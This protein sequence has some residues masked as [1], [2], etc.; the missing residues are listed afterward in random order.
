MRNLNG[1]KYLTE[2]HGK[3]FCAAPW[4]SIHEGPGGLVSTCCKSREP[5]GWSQDQT[6]EEMYNSDHAKSVRSSI[7]R[8]E[9]HSNC[10][11]C[12]IQ[13]VEGHPASNRVH[14]NTM[15]ENAVIDDLVANTDPDG[16]LHVHRPEWLDLLWTNKCNFACLGCSPELSSTINN[17]YQEEFALLNG[18]RPENYYHNYPN[19]DNGNTNKIDYI[20]KHSDTIQSLHLNGGEPWMQEA[21]YELLEEMLKRGLNKTIQVWSHT[22][23]SI[24]KS[25]KGVDILETYL[26]H[27]G[28]KCKITISNDGHGDRGAYTRYGYK[29]SKWLDTYDRIRQSGLRNVSIQTCWNVFNAQTLSDTAEFYLENCTIG[30]GRVHGSLSPWYNPT[31]TPLMLSYVPELRERAIGQIKKLMESGRH[32]GS[33]AGDLQKH[34]DYLHRTSEIDNKYSLPNNAALLAWYAGVS[35]LDVKRKT[36][37]RATFPELTPLWDL[38]VTETERQKDQTLIRTS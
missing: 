18:E 5:I 4:N 32:P 27:W 35:A 14:S 15:T 37:L 7:L 31:T 20:I 34:L 11:A 25:Y 30:D 13:E 17:R 26:V 21:T 1:H 2:K 8:G 3:F 19:W 22:N 29:E 36:D 6:F 28:N 23:G 38:A 16:T 9:M 24:T 10:K 33:W 12:A